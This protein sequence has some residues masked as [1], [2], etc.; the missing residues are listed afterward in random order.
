M[1]G[2]LFTGGIHLP[3]YLMEQERFANVILSGKIAAAACSFRM[4]LTHGL[5]IEVAGSP[6]G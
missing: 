5:T 1:P 2:L 3:Q 4:S 6:A